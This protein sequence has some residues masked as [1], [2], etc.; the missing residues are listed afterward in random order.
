MGTLI[1]ELQEV[2]ISGLDLV[3]PRRPIWWL[4]YCNIKK[5]DLVAWILERHADR[6]GGLDFEASRT[7][8]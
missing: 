2:L 8:I 7:L 1:L 5:A 3:V 6:Y 4:G